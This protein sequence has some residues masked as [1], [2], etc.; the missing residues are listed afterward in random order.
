MILTGQNIDRSWMQSVLARETPDVGKVSGSRTADLIIYATAHD[1][2]TMKGTSLVAD[3]TV[4]QTSLT[5]VYHQR[6]I[7]GR[8]RQL[9]GDRLGA[10]QEFSQ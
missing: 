2:H 7:I 10:R 3:K 5:P 4:Q 6:V 1:W 8:E 9:A